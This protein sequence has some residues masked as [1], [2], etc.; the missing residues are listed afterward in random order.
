MDKSIHQN[1]LICN[2]YVITFTFDA[3]ENTRGITKASPDI[4]EFKTSSKRQDVRTR[5]VNYSRLCMTS[6]QK[7]QNRW[8][9]LHVC[10]LQRWKDLEGGNGKTTK[11]KARG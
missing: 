7:T 8:Y 4:K 3:M 10:G 2:Y 9:V 5:K 6:C 1:T 11:A